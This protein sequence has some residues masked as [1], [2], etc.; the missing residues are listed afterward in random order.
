MPGP[1]ASRRHFLGI[2]SGLALGAQAGA[3]PLPQDD[4]PQPAP[5]SAALADEAIELE[6]DAHLRARVCSR[7]SG[8]R[9]LLAPAA[10]SETLELAGGRRIEDFALTDRSLEAVDD[11]HGKGRRLTIVGV[12]HE[13]IQKTLQATL[14]ERFPGFVMVRVAYRSLSESPLE[15]RAWS[16]G[17]FRVQAQGPASPRFWSFSGGTYP[18][19][20]D[21]VRPVDEG[22]AQDNFMGM[23]ASDYGSGTPIV[24]L[25]RRD[26]GIAVGHLAPTPQA[27][28]LPIRAH[29][30]E[31]T[32]AVQCRRETPLAPGATFETLET[33]VA[34]HRGDHFATLDAYRRIMADRGMRA[35]APSAASYESMWCAWG[36]ERECTVPLIEGT[37]PK[38]RDLGLRWAVIDDGWQNDVGDWRLNPQK[39]PD[40]EAGMRELV[41]R[42]RGADLKPR[43]WW[44]PLAVAPGSDV[45]HDQ[46]DMLLLDRD[47][48]V[49]NISWWNCFYLCPAYDKTLAY[50][51]ALV[52]RFIGEWGFAGLKIDGQH[53]NGVAPCYNPAHRH[54]RPEESVEKL[55]D[56]FRAV[57]AEAHRALPDAVVELCVCGTSYAFYNVPAFDQSPA[58]DPESSWQV[59]LKGKSMK[60]L[61]GPSAAFA[62]DHVELSDR[63]DDFASTVG[64]GGIVSTKFTWPNDPKPKDSFLLTPER[65]ALWRRWIGLYNEKMLPQGRYRGELYDIGF[66][67]PEAHVVEKDGRFYYAF[68][69]PRWSGPIALRGLPD[70]RRYALRDYF[71]ARELGTVTSARNVLHAAF[72]R[73]LLIEA[74]PA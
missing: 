61:A 19:R 2:A 65:E 62:G 10:A 56:F 45:L 59:R 71:N 32:I 53:L 49:Q 5:R 55:Q 22:F 41:A 24:D 67:K 58:S 47:G 51:L 73:H 44:A 70:G 66:D 72:E 12:A 39:F 35:P 31:A 21:W 9:V 28:S 18:D 46:T 8:R 74:V 50:T 17:S 34:V 60:A 7:T 42:I 13:G 43:L 4:S 48:A 52:R 26:G 54:A 68:Y 1:S 27:V 11:V 64:I 15:L 69:A 57:Y 25:W 16:N 36:Y 40:G 6:F 38:V 29:A 20:R 30:G 37:L 3:L 23:T 14:Y 33:F 63:G